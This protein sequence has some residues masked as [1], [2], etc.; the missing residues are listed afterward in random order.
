MNTR[1]L[2]E[3]AKDKRHIPGIYNYCD[4]W[5]ERCP[6]SHRC[7]NYSM[8]RENDD[9]DPEARD[10]NN[11]KFWKK[12][13]ESFAATLKMIT[14]HAKEMGV[15]LND[16][17]PAV[18]EK[19]R[20]KRERRQS[21]KHPAAKLSY[22]YMM[23]VREVQKKLKPA[24]KAKGVELTTQA[25]LG[26]A[27]PATEAGEIEECLDVIGWYQMFIHVKITRALESKLREDEEMDEEM[28]AFPKDSEGSAKIALIGI[29]RSIAAWSLLRDR[30]EDDSLL[31]TL[32]QLARVRRV[33]EEAFPSA[34]AF[35]R[36]GF[37]T[38]E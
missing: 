23:A 27:D 13:H 21:R 24:L 38:G 33:T 6:L 3:L 34:R 29:D 19:L 26:I 36:P 20:A 30:L 16:T 15:D 18:E 14:E 35:V 32:A 11:E 5:C 37:D 25:K 2:K 8:E 9:G 22:D 31:D 12:M 4:R 1:R 10:M 17:M 7:L 28:R